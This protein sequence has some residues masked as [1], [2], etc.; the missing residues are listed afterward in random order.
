M[1]DGV[2]ILPIWAAV[3]AAPWLLLELIV[4]LLRGE[5]LRWYWKIT[6]IVVGVLLFP[7]SWIVYLVAFDVPL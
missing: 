1:S 4:C 3:M 7:F 5:W 2:A 6:A